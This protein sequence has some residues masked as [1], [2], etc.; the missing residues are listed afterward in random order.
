[1][2]RDRST[3]WSLLKPG[4]PRNGSD[5]R[6]DITASAGRLG[7]WSVHPQT[8]VRGSVEPTRGSMR[9]QGM[10][11][12][13]GKV[14]VAQTELASDDVHLSTRGVG[15]KSIAGDSERGGMLQPVGGV[16]DLYRSQRNAMM[17]LARL[18]TDS[19]AVA[20]EIVQE[21]FI[22]FARSPGQKDEP[23]AYLRVIVV[24]L[25]RSQQRRTLLE[26]RIA[27]KAPL[28][29]GI[30]EIDE[31]W[32]LVRTLPFRQRAVL[33]LRYYED[34]S[35]A[36]IARVLKCRPGTVKSALHRGLA[37]LRKQLGDTESAPRGGQNN[38]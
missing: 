17:R 16:E 2:G 20:E 32:D 9:H 8:Q 18:L 13:T 15:P 37:A 5:D 21:A 23:A 33:M 26:R 35:E 10:E 31:T 22:R 14:L 24:N 28:L 7:V 27:P 3:P 6:C 19:P 38:A 11:E 29:S 12:T 4:R 34:L 25:C 30:P 36:D 1:M